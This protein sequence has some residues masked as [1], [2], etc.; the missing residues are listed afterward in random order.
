[1]LDRSLPQNRI[2]K[3]EIIV[4]SFWMELQVV[5]INDIVHVIAYLAG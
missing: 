1:V 2:A 5:P 4:E 3:V